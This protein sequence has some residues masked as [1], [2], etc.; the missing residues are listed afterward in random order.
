MKQNSVLKKMTEMQEAKNKAAIA[1]RQQFNRNPP[2]G[3]K[4]RQEFFS[5]VKKRKPLFEIAATKQRLKFEAEMEA[6]AKKAGW[7]NV[8]KSSTSQVLFNKNYP[9]FHLRIAEAAEIFKA[10]NFPLFLN[11]KPVTGPVSIDK[12]EKMLKDFKG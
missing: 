3:V 5:S 12:L 2:P 9:G 10:G 8:F 11:D 4:E 1:G 7:K 6:V